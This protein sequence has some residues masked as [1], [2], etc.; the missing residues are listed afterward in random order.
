MSSS[1]QRSSEALQKIR[2]FP[3]VRAGIVNLEKVLSGPSYHAGSTVTLD[4]PD[5]RPPTPW[6]PHARWVIV[7]GLHHPAD[8]PM[9]DWWEGGN[10]KG[11]RRLMAITAALEGWFN[12]E[13]GLGTQS[14]PY[15]LE[16]GGL[17]QKDAAVL[18]GLGIVGRNNLLV[19]PKWGPQIR[20]RSMLVAGDL[21]PTKPL[22]GFDPCTDCKRFC[23]KA[24]PQRAFPQG[25]Y[26][27]EKCMVQMQMD[28]E[29]AAPENRTDR[30]EKSIPVTKYCRAC[31]LAC[32]VG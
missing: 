23:Q 9:L 21:E 16:R 13:L 28:I 25:R 27:R 4:P 6:L 29:H 14:L 1:Y 17:F 22:D 12:K 15:Y 26:N 3:G 31:E 8:S 24:C 18:S 32:P 5:D 30:Q 10:T 2:E 19:H 20:F 7:L 11:N